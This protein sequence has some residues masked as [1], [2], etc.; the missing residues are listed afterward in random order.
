MMVPPSG[1]PA[2]PTPMPPPLALLAELTHRCPMR[3]IYCSNPLAL[4]PASRELPT[5]VWGRAL[6]EAA[7]L[8]VLQVSFSGGEPLVRP[9]LALLVAAARAA[10]L[11]TNLITSAVLLTGDE[12]VRLADAG[13]DHIQISIQDTDVAAG[14]R[15]GG[16]KGAQARKIAAARAVTAAGLAL[17]INA[18]VHRANAARVPQMIELALALGAG[19]IEIAHV[20]YH[21]WALANRAALL[22]G[23]AEVDAVSAAVEAARVA[24]AGR[25]VIDHVLP[26]YHARLPKACM[27]GWG[28]RALVIDPAGRVLPCHAATTIPGM[29]FARVGDAPL[30]HI[31]QRDDAFTRFRGT[32]WM[33]EPCASC[34]RREVDWGGCRCQALALTGDAAATDP[35]CRKSPYRPI[36]DSIAAGAGSD[37]PA[38]PI[39]RGTPHHVGRPSPSRAEFHASPLPLTGD[40]DRPSGVH[41]ATD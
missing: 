12:V 11:Y 9:D 8:G 13:I 20:Q 6:E 37:A 27:G 31:W 19:R 18:V 15:V 34:E 5:A 26:D 29:A 10:G 30:A 38:E 17:T 40:S 22:P 28:Q 33:A 1:P 7:D 3:C 36:I 41:P 2:G 23:R 32:A 21:G 39:Y 14:E 4:E 25:L 24:C 35:V 16:L